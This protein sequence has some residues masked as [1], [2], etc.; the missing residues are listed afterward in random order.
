MHHI[1]TLLLENERFSYTNHHRKQ[2][3]DSVMCL[4]LMCC[5]LPYSEAS[6]HAVAMLCSGVFSHNVFSKV[7]D[8]FTLACPNCQR[9]YCVQHAKASLAS[10][11]NTLSPDK[12]Q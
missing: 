4:H 5:V 9:T 10:A 6:E 12:P 2:S 1:L 3:I 8:H 11:L 7:I